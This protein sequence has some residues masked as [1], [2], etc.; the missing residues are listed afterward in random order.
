MCMEKTP[1][2]K[3]VEFHGHS[4]PG[5]AIGFKVAEIALKHLQEMRSQDEELVAI[6]EN[7]A[8]SVD[9]VQVMTG[10]T[11]GKGNLIY[12]DLGKQVYTFGSRS[13]SRALRISVN[14]DAR[15]PDPEMTELRQKVFGGSA[16]QEDRAKF[17]LAQG[18]RIEQILHMDENEFCKIEQIDFK[19][20]QKAK[21]FPSHK[22]ASC[23]EMVMEPRLRVKNGEFVC[24]DCFEDYSRGW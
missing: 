9:A 23:G 4:C 22:C 21:I 20:P 11:M 3:A 19:L 16:S 10:C 15:R 13:G 2:E 5:L 12:R 1:W 24:L 14:G 8:C 7:D 17:Q 18:R 6:V